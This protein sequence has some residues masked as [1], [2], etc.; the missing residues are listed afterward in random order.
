M[1]NKI[2]GV[3]VFNRSVLGND[4]MYYVK[5]G[6]ECFDWAHH[7]HHNMIV[8][9]QRLCAKVQ[10]TLKRVIQLGKVE[11]EAEQDALRYPQS[12]LDIY[13][14]AYHAKQEIDALAKEIAQSIR[15]PGRVLEA[16]IKS[17]Q[18]A[19]EKIH[20]D[21]GGNV[22]KITDLARNTLIVD[23]R[24]FRKVCEKLKAR[25][26]RLKVLLE[27][28][29]PS[30][31]SG[32]NA[33]LTTQTGL[34]AEVKIN[35]PQMIYTE[36]PK[37]KAKEVLGEKL[38]CKID[39]WARVHGFR[40]GEGHK[41]YEKLR[42]LGSQD[43]DKKSKIEKKSQRYYFQIRNMPLRFQD[44]TRIYRNEHEQ[45]MK[46]IIEGSAQLQEGRSSP[47]PAGSFMLRKSRSNG[48]TPLITKQNL[49]AS[50]DWSLTLP[51][52]AIT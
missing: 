9:T 5:K 23:P 38:F 20:R 46:K 47:R 10:D 40:A 26:A 18:R 21:Y 30:G 15:P 45:A 33:T 7:Q 34:I 6:K 8:E 43:T 51:D 2:I 49:R 37:N 41:L 11:E 36:V 52:T 25:G 24:N 1:I 17:K 31:Y 44:G 42:A 16:P 35:S 27:E 50:L 32:I 22:N 14:K 4:P 28:N 3:P 29:V 13:R 12:F 48:H 19:M 39:Q